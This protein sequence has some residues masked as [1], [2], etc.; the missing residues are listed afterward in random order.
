MIS[1]MHPATPPRLHPRALPTEV[2]CN[3][4]TLSPNSPEETTYRMATSPSTLTSS[5]LTPKSRPPPTT[6]SSVSRPDPQCSG[7]VTPNNLLAR[8]IIWI[9]NTTTVPSMRISSQLW[10]GSP[11]PCPARNAKATER[12]TAC[13]GMFVRSQ[14]ASN[15][16]ARSFSGYLSPCTSGLWLLTDTYPLSP[17][18][19]R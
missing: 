14:I 19:Q 6:L 11:G 15:V 8:A 5:V 18:D 9:V 3:R 7:F 12:L 16:E 4:S 17:A 1:M 10:N 13:S 2:T